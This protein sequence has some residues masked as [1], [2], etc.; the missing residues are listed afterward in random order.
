MAERLF[1]T[2]VSEDEYDSMQDK[3][4]RIPPGKNGSDQSGDTLYESV[5][6]GVAEWKTPGKVLQVE[7]T[8][9]SEG[10]NK[11]KI[12]LWYP[13]LESKP[14]DSM[15]ITKQGLK[16][17]GIEDKVLR[18]VEGKIKINP[19]GFAGAKAKALFIREWSKPQDINKAPILR[20]VLDSSSF[21]P[22]DT[23]S[24]ETKELGI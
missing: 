5:Q 1:D 20:A 12:V 6:A 21:L 8:V 13:G 3:F 11:G 9:I 23:K 10:I 17:F 14:K 19:L 15:S 16:A 22:I 4:I 18:R 24:S 2:N 7:L